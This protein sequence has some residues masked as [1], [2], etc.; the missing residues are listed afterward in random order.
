M[1]TTEEKSIYIEDYLLKYFDGYLI[2][3]I[4][5][6]RDKNF[7]FTF[8]YILLVSSGIDFLGGLKDGFTN[9]S[10]VRFCDFI[11]DW[12]IKS[13]ELYG[14]KGMSEVIYKSARC[15]CSHQA[16]F[17]KGIKSSTSCYPKEKHLYHFVDLEGRDS[18]FL[19]AFQFVED[20]LKAQG[21]FRQT[22]IKNNPDIV[23]K[24]LTEMLKKDV[25]ELPELIEK[26]KRE[27]L[28]FDIEEYMK[29]KESNQAAFGPSGPPPE[30]PIHDSV[31]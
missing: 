1:K 31:E 11:K 26:L 30:E 16:I 22:Y 25:E 3:D 6:I 15:G 17:N 21:L 18:I 13:N 20:F 23:Y 19:H 9:N 5:S 2:N 28:T 24:N 12:M 14:Y 8:P 10:R 4:R 7:D 27:G 29:N